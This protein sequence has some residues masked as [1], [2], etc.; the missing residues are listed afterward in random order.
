LLAYLYAQFVIFFVYG[1]AYAIVHIKLMNY[2]WKLA[3]YGAV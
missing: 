3:N 2:I 1:H